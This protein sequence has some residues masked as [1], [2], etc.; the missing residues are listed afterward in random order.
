MSRPLS[1]RGWRGRVGWVLGLGALGWVAAEL[2]RFEPEPLPYVLLVAVVAALAWLVLDTTDTEPA[3]WAPPSPT[4]GDRVDE[5]TSDLRVLTSH[6]QA[7]SPSEAV[8]ERLLALARGRD[9]AL[10]ERLHEELG[11]PARRL[12]PAE[13]DRILTRI[14]DVDDRR[15]PRP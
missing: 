10:A 2:L 8:R 7:S 15:D 6:Q 14:E 13:I 11:G 9:P 4:R 12:S 5:A 1:W 3:Q